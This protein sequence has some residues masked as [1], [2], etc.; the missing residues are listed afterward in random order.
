MTNIPPVPAGN[1]SP[2]PLE[3]A[4]AASATTASDDGGT[5][6]AG[7]RDAAGEQLTAA[8]DAVGDQ[9]AAARDAVGP[10]AD[11]AR[12]FATARPW[13]TAALVGTIGLAVLNTLRGRRA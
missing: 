13:A 3:T 1:Q 9:L 2:Y 6:I 12:A 11:K 8:R 4:P 5:R 7:A 10:L